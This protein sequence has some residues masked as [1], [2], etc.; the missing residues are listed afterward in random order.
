[1]GQYEGL[2]FETNTSCVKTWLISMSTQERFH[3][4]LYIPLPFR[5]PTV[6]SHLN[7]SEWS[8]KVYPRVKYNK[9]SRFLPRVYVC[10]CFTAHPRKRNCLRN[11]YMTTKKSSN[12]HVPCSFLYFHL[13]SGQAKQIIPC[14]FF[15]S[16]FVTM[17]NC[18][19]FGALM[20]D[21]VSGKLQQVRHS[22]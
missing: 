15:R 14:L 8:E 5:F 4:F 10:V 21:V 20:Y 13:D 7:T 6:V 17:S 18:S 12:F 9:I 22:I 11:M 1:M 16:H 19:V 3:F 2:S